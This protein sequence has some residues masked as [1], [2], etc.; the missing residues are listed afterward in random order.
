LKPRLETDF[1]PDSRIGRLWSDVKGHYLKEHCPASP[2]PEECL[3]SLEKD[4]H[5]G[6]NSM[7]HGWFRRISH[8]SKLLAS[9]A[10]D[11][12]YRFKEYYPYLAKHGFPLPFV[13]DDE[14]VKKELFAVV[15]G[16]KA[17]L[18]QD[19]L[20]PETP[21]Y[22]M[23]MIK[24]IGEWGKKALAFEKDCGIELPAGK[25]FKDKC[26]DD[27]EKSTILYVLYEYAGLDPHFVKVFGNEP[28]PLELQRILND[29]LDERDS[30]R[31]CIGIKVNGRDK[32]FLVDPLEN[33]LDPSYGD[34]AEYSLLEYVKDGWFN[35]RL[36]NFIVNRQ[37]EAMA[38][39]AKFAMELSPESF[40][41]HQ[42]LF[43]TLIKLDR[44]ESAKRLVQVIKK[45]FEKDPLALPY[46]LY[47]KLAVGSNDVSNDPIVEQLEEAIKQIGNIEP[48]AAA[49]VADRLS[50]NMLINSHDSDSYGMAARK[51]MLELAFRVFKIGMEYSE[52]YLSSFAG[53]FEVC[54]LLGR[55]QESAGFFKKY[56]EKRPSSA[57]GHYLAAR[58]SLDLAFS[59]PRKEMAPL[60]QEVQAHL[61]EMCRL[62]DCNS[63][64]FKD[65]FL[66][67]K[68]S[69]FLYSGRSNEAISILEEEYKRAPEAFSR[70][71]YHALLFS[72][73]AVGR[74]SE[75]KGFIA[76]DLKRGGNKMRDFWVKFIYD[77]LGALEF[78]GK[79]TASKSGI[80]KISG[81]ELLTGIIDV[82]SST[83]D[84]IG[85]EERY[86]E[87]RSVIY[88]LL[89]VQALQGG[90]VKKAENLFASVEEPVSD[91]AQAALQVLLSSILLQ[92]NAISE[93]KLKEVVQFTDRAAQMFKGL[94][95]KEISFL[96][97]IIARQCMKSGDFK[98]ADKR[99]RS[100]FS[101]G[102]K[103]AFDFYFENVAKALV[104]EAFED[105][106]SRPKVSAAMTA[107][108]I[109]IET[110]PHCPMRILRDI[111]KGLGGF[112][113]VK[114][115]ERIKKLGEKIDRIILED[116]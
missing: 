5:V 59:T 84:L 46:L 79:N 91:E 57:F 4:A 110:T 17:R 55:G 27:T 78:E 52:R 2:D 95:D 64:S 6:Y 63:R 35:N 98:Q 69:I 56:S 13:V 22:Q 83:A 11:Y 114:D 108:E 99:I 68:S 61:D 85:E 62:A 47:S 54:E 72:Y 25:A 101:L 76:E 103:D 7:D 58:A 33:Q 93:A 8:P 38:N 82:F 34:I 10:V 39:E 28:T 44:P 97:L 107:L 105:K 53:F 89:A 20:K 23:A 80:I 29:S 106:A 40:T 36:W 14:E 100:A 3:A 50:Y 45:K 32:L 104:M 92:V 15:D 109:C 18:I 113:G 67:A 60:L 73:A 48:R 42:I 37:Y 49:Q 96:Y 115:I 74:F 31:I 16:I 1:A 66:A 43:N 9:E 75:A 102:A 90:E 70:N 88:L 26:G 12:V 86:K 41:L 81:K 94:A 111:R 65:Q 21:E 30:G 71:L 77:Q 19:G 87:Q 51:R 24:G 116:R 112:E